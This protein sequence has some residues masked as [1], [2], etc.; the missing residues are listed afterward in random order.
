M[1]FVP[2]SSRVGLT[3]PHT[4]AQLRA[5]LAKLAKDLKD[6]KTDITDLESDVSDLL[7][8]FRREAIAAEALVVGDVV[9]LSAADT[10]TKARANAIGTAKPEGVVTR[11]APSGG[12]V[13]YAPA[14]VVEKPGWGLTVGAE[15]FLSSATAGAIVT[16]PD[17]ETAGTVAIIIGVAL[18]T[19]ELLVKIQQS[20]LH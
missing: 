17:S 13:E 11:S 9:Y 12:I 8:G 3:N 5:A 2:G 10:V 1:T 7:A 4:P 18:S 16:A 6:D 15:Y 14:G 20:V 19:T